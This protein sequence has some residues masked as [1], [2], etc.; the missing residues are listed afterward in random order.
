L[1]TKLKNRRKLKKMPKVELD[2]SKEHSMPFNPKEARESGNLPET[3]ARGSPIGVDMPMDG[4]D[5]PGVPTGGDPWPKSDGGAKHK[6]SEFSSMITSNGE[7]R[8]AWPK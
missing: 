4:T 7:L 1:V 6:T 5:N 3:P 8:K 2:K